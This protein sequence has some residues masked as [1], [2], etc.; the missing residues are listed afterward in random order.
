MLMAYAAAL[1]LGLILFWAGW[2]PWPLTSG[3]A[4]AGGV[5]VALVMA[6]S[7]AMRIT[8]REGAP[9]LRLP[10]LIALRAAGL[11]R[12]ANGAADV[13]RRSLAGDAKLHPALVRFRTRTKA[14][15]SRA[16][17]ANAL[18]A[19]GAVVVEADE[20]SLLVHVLIED[21]ADEKELREL[22]AR[23]WRADS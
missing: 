3:W 13:A 2:A 21:D 17:F 20:E 22:E 18:A 23:G 10:K 5:S 11:G 1:A 4:L 19:P 6:L 8:D 9:Y 14:G 16:A 12:V 15:A 7:I